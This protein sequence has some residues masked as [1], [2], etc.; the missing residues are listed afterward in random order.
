VLLLPTL[1]SGIHRNLLVQ[2][3]K[4]G[5]IYLVDI[6]SM[7][8]FCSSCTSDTQIVQE[9]PQAVHGMWSMPAYWN[10]MAYFWGSGDIG[11]SDFMKVYSFNA[12]NSGL[13]SASP[14]AESSMSYGFPGATPAISAN[15]NTNGIVWTVRTDAYPNGRAVLYAY[16]A[17]NVAQ[18]LYDSSQASNNRDTLATAAK[19][20]VPTISNS[21]VYAGANGQLSAFGLL[22]E[23]GVATVARTSTHMDVFFV[24]PDGSIRQV[25]WEYGG[26]WIVQGNIAPPGSAQPG[27]GVAV[28]ARSSTHMDVFYIGR[29]GSVRQVWW[30]YGG[31]WTLEGNVAPPG[32]A[33]P[34]SGVTAV[35]R[36]STHMDVFYIGP[37]GSIRQVWWQYPNAWVLQGSIAPAGSAYTLTEIAAVARTSTH[38]D[39]FYIGSD[40]SI[41]QVWWEYGGPW[42]LEGNVAPPGSAQP[43]TGITVVARTSTHMDIFWVGTDG[44]VS[45]VWWEYGGPWVLQGEI[46][47]PGT[48]SSASHSQE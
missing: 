8:H 33:Q 2:A 36:S 9:I 38:M 44:S 22:H 5:K 41:R 4:Q 42:I 35:T 10:G 43:G 3:G 48:S 21:K 25:W 19:F 45:Q 6:N 18:E 37:D 7:G 17:T 31:P 46:A 29:D 14:I 34:G 47:P 15:G 24:G 32:S 40:G 30:E 23:G 11:D 27:S 28:V 20:S 39:I 26:S 12:N 1:S 13:L 16:N